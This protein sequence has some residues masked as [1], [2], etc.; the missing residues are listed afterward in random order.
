MDQNQIKRLI[1]NGSVRASL[2]RDSQ[3]AQLLITSGKLTISK[4]KGNTNVKT[5]N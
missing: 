2:T 5:N 4:L 3:T 1:Q